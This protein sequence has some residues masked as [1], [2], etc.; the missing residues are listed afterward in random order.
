LAQVENSI[1]KRRCFGFVVSD[2]QYGRAASAQ[3][4]V[5]VFEQSTVQVYV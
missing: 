3:Q 2:M 5:E 1:G 4:L